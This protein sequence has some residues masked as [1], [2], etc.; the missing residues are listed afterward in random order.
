MT[1]SLLLGRSVAN[2]GTVVKTWR[3]YMI[4]T[5]G[6][7]AAFDASGIGDTLFIA[8]LGFALCVRGQTI[9]MMLLRTRM[10]VPVN[11]ERRG[12]PLFRLAIRAAV[13]VGGFLPAVAVGAVIL[14]WTQH[15]PEH[16]PVFV[17][18]L[19]SV[20]GAAIWMLWN[21]ILIGRKLDPL[22]NRYSGLAVVRLPD[23]IRRNEFSNPL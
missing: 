13:M 23:R 15:D 11:S 3:S 2:A 8:Y 1:R 22:Y 16:A 12:V 10:I 4:S 20:M 18:I 17:G 14:L 9:G 6:S 7:P 21:A 19:A 5:D